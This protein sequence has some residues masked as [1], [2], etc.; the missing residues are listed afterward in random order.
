VHLRQVTILAALLAATSAA[1]GTIDNP[2]CKREL[3]AASATVDEAARLKPPS[4]RT[5][6]AACAAY[7]NQFL[8]LVRARAIVAACKTGSDRDQEVTRLDGTVE[9]INGF[10]A[11]SCGGT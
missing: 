5:G 9:D 6:E 10:I 4:V 1:A 3:A 7:R 2:R 11:Q 8:S